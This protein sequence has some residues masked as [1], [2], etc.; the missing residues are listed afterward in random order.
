V[1][2]AG[3]RRSLY[4]LR[5]ISECRIDAGL[6]HIGRFEHVRGRPANQGSI[7]FSYLT[8]AGRTFGNRPFDAM[9]TQRKE[10]TAARF[11]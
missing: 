2:S 7:G 4:P 1:N 5:T 10:A 9:L 3:R 6:P 11:A 8:I